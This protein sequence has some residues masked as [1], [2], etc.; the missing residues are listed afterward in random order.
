MILKN[1][2]NIVVRNNRSLVIYRLLGLVCLGVLLLFALFW[3]SGLDLFKN[4]STISSSTGYT[5]LAD[6]EDTLGGKFQLN[7]YEL[8]GGAYQSADYAFEGKYSMKLEA[9]DAQYGFGYE[10]PNVMQGDEVTVKVWMY[11][12][13]GNM[14]CITLSSNGEDKIYSESCEA[15]EEKGDWLLLELSVYISKKLE[16]N[17]LKIFCYNLSAQ[18]VYFDNLSYKIAAKDNNSWQPETVQLVLKEGEYLKLKEKR[19]EALKRGVLLSED[20][21][22]VKGALY[23]KDYKA[24]KIKVSL[25]LKGDWTDH[26]KGEHW[27]FRVETEATK[28][29]NRLKVFS[30]QTPQTRSYLHEWVLHQFF[31]YEDVL[32]PRYDF[33]N[34]ILND[35]DLGLY[36][37]EEH[38]VKQIPEYN[39][40]RE[41]PIV[42]FT[43]NGFWEGQLQVKKTKGKVHPAVGTN[44]AHPDIRPFKEGKTF[45]SENLAQQFEIAQNLMYAYQFGLKPAKDIF[46]LDILAKYFVITDIMGGHHG[47][48]WHNQ[49]YYYNPVIGKL[50][51]IGFDGFGE[52]VETWLEEPFIGANRSDPTRPQEWFNRLFLDADFLQKYYYYLDK[53]T[54][55]QYLKDF[56]DTIRVDL[57]ERLAVIRK[58]KT[59]YSFSP[60]YFYKRAAVIRVALMPTETVLQS[61]TIEPGLIA[62]CNRHA[63]P[64]EVIGTTTA[65]DGMLFRLDS[66]ALVYT[67]L[68]YKLPDYSYQIQVPKAAKYLV[69]K[70]PGIAQLYYAEINPWSV[71]EAYTPMQELAANLRTEHPAYYYDAAAHK[72]VFKKDGK[73]SEPIIIPANHQVLF[74]A[75]TKLDITQKAFVISYSPVHFYGT[76]EEPI[77]IHSS[78]ASA[79]GF[80]VIKAADKSLM[81]YTT[82][83]NFNTLAYKGWNLTGAVTFYESDVDIS[84]SV[85][86]KNHCE[87]ALNIIRSKFKFYKSTVSHTF[88]DGFDADFCTGLVDKGYFYETGNDGI[89]FSTSVITIK[90]TKIENAGD[91]GISIGEQGTST[92]INTTIDGAVIGIASKDLSK[93]TVVSANLKNCQEGFAAYQKKPEYGGGFIYVQDYTAEGVKTLYRILPGSELTLIDKEIKGDNL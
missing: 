87:D 50:E 22:W 86:T 37:Y 45:K 91:K 80:T 93:V 31:K 88:G 68:G 73:T 16:D 53:F 57:L 1:K 54:A 9:P 43:E 36:V 20:D 2:T 15:W 72:V 81:N 76:Q 46:D 6:A 18:T 82:F 7:G 23:P 3:M 51:P 4:K 39:L 24:D 65:K 10:I 40:K 47:V 77:L 52:T 14:G 17:R 19:N 41:G 69:Y 26:L 63:V 90:D 75:G 49:R 12:P 58:H 8:E 60:R 61:R 34:L 13:F 79:N 29:W 55:E 5:L 42:K 67:T 74:E 38:F 56:T 71:P 89:D 28:S 59:D 11:S 27:S 84:N 83:S 92:V 35:K 70:L 48:V 21:S 62:L 78:D 32:T 64:L 85:F 66:V 33:I 30:L 25:R 44:K